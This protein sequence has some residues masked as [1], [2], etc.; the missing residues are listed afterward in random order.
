VV[1]GV[2]LNWTNLR[3]ALLSSISD[4]FPA[5]EL[6]AAPP[7]PVGH[8]ARLLTTL[9][10]KLV[11]GYVSSNETNL[12]TPVRLSLAFAWMFVVVA[13]GSIALLLHG[14]LSLSERRAAFVSA[15]T[16]E[17]RTPLMTFRMYSEMLAEGMV[18]DEK[19]RRQY[20]A[21]LCS[22]ATRLSHLVENVLS[23]ARLERRSAR[24]RIE[25]VSLGQLIGRVQPR[26]TE[27]AAM[28]GLTLV[29][30]L[31]ATAAHARMQ[32]DVAAVEQILFNLVDNACKY[33]APTASNKNLHLQAQ[34]EDSRS[35]RVRVRDHGP[36]LSREVTHQLF[37]PFS[38]SA[39]EAAQTAPGVGL[40]LA[41]CRGLARSMGGELRLIAGKGEPAGACFELCLPVEAPGPATLG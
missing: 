22:E 33:A 40:G 8:E 31:D 28:A 14:T 13:A 1:Q 10:V 6:E 30:Q 3:P 41:L 20:L 35:V 7:T 12:W 29:E 11:P 36:G 25:E 18:T 19:Q 2:W 24:E 16:H 15:V 32:V 4:L 37:Q 5:A 21:T 38:K 17:M 26:L 39:D 27:R 34:L 9:P 23:Y